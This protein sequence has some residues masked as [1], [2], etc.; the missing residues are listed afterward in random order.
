[1]N[2]VLDTEEFNVYSSLMLII[3]L[4]TKLVFTVIIYQIPS[5]LINKGKTIIFKVEINTNCST[6]DN[7]ISASSF[8]RKKMGY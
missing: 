2:L 1:M 6:V 8:V 7:T 4:I 5:K 3:Y